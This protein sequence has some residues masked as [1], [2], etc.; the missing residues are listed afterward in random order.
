MKIDTLRR[1]ALHYAGYGD[2]TGQCVQFL[3]S[4]GLPIT[5]GDKD[6]LTPIHLA[7]FRGHKLAVHA[8]LDALRGTAA[9]AALNSLDSMGRSPTHYAVCL[10]RLS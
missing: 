2:N 3:I 6:R 7:C 10:L 8:M 4:E 1:T 9:T 5:Q